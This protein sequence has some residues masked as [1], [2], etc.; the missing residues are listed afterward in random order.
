MDRCRRSDVALPGLCLWHQCAPSSNLDRRSGL[1]KLGRMTKYTVKFAK[2]RPIVI[3]EHGTPVAGAQ[4]RTLN[5]PSGPV[6][7]VADRK[8]GP[9]HRPATVDIDV[10]GTRMASVPV[11]SSRRLD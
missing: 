1:T 4:V 6:D 3:D 7:V 2:G 10:N 8:W 5:F 11:Q 9:D